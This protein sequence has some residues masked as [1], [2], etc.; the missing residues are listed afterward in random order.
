M[1]FENWFY[2]SLVHVL[3]SA[4]YNCSVVEI[5][6]IN[7]SFIWLTLAYKY[8][9]NK[10]ILAL[11]H[12]IYIYINY[13]KL[14][15]LKMKYN[16]RIQTGQ[17]EAHF[18][19][20]TAACQ[21]AE[22]PVAHWVSSVPLVRLVRLPCLSVR[23]RHERE[24]RREGTHIPDGLSFPELGRRRLGWPVKPHELW[25]THTIGVKLCLPRSIPFPARSRSASE[26][27]WHY[28]PIWC[29]PRQ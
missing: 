14:W 6:H 11:I 29:G 1:K 16:S 3:Y 26:L 15:L 2:L 13:D 8:I 7:I 19:P 5:Y 9:L 4:T 20:T 27:H 12:Y 18:C 10:N 25:R 24:R 23:T 28:G 21:R 22:C 17:R